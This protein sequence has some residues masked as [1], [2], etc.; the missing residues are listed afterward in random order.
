VAI[1]NENE[2]MKHLLLLHGAIGAKDQ[3]QPLTELLKNDFIVHVFNFSGHGGKPFSNESFSI[4]VFAIEVEEYLSTQNIQQPSVFG[5]SMGGYVALYLAK[6]LPQLLSEIV[7]LATKFNW[8]EAAAAKEAAMLN[9]EVLQD[10]LP[11]FAEQLK[12]RHHPNDWKLLFE[13]TKTMLLQ[14]GKHNPLQLTDYSIIRQPV[15]LLLGDNDKMVT[16][17]E[18]EAVLQAL[19]NSRFQ[20][21]EQTSHPIEKVNSSALARIIREF[22]KEKK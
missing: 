6:K 2:H 1:N 10:K 7:T 18:T 14:M 22:C 12:Q 19:P 11:A 17:E 20:L 4:Q 5:Y 21:L 15:L 8:D 3:L 9:A 16:R 13:K